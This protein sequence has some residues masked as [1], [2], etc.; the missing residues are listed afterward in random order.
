[1]QIRYDSATKCW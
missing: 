1:V